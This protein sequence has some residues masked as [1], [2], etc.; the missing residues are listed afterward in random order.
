[1]Q[2]VTTRPNALD[3]FLDP[4]FLSLDEL[5]DALEF[6]VAPSG[7]LFGKHGIELRRCPPERRKLAI[8]I[9]GGGASGAYNAGLLEELLRGLR[10]RGIKV[11][12]LVGTSSGA[13]NGYGV[14]LEALGLGNPQLKT[15]PSIRQPFDSYIASAWS[16]LDRD[17][18]ASRWVVGRRSWIVQFA[19]RGLPSGW[20]KVG[21]ALLLVAMAALLQ[22]NLLLPLGAMA[23]RAGTES[24]DWIV[25]KSL[26]QS[27]PALFGCAL[28][29]T[30]LL[31][32]LGWLIARAF[33]QSLFLDLPLLR[34]L[35]NTGPDGDLGR[36]PRLSRGQAVDRARN[37]SRD[38]AD[39]WYR[40]R[41]ELPEFVITVTD[42]TAGRECLFTLVR[43]ET[44]R[45]L[46]R[47]EWMAIQFDSEPEIS[48]EYG[49]GSRAMFALPENLLRSVVASS[50][51]PG[52]FPTQRIGIYPAGREQVA[53]HHFVD[54]GVLNNSPVHVAIDAGA[55][56][57]ISLEILPLYCRDPLSGEER[58]AG[59]YRLLDAALATFTTVLERATHED[60]RR[61]ASWNRFLMAHP[62]ALGPGRGSAGRAE[63]QR[64]VVPVYRIAPRDPLVGT[65]E[66]DGRFEEG[67]RTVT[68]RDL[69]RQGILDMRGRNAWTATVRPQPG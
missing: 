1:M 49:S 11:G 64:R 27:V 55:T 52:A 21:L 47:R 38:I 45:L 68:L 61:T 7:G 42:I 10:R 32:V 51:V 3:R 48:A 54:G 18:K 41:L 33:R 22:P 66:F 5:L 16:Y 25:T 56:H 57:V 15:D 30:G 29:A 6:E 28:A 17:G 44:Y 23:A 13:V 12:L 24:L 2:Q 34:F 40:R 58:P 46:R 4:G 8:A 59:D 39:A 53:R 26:A 69:L 20:R 37:L 9:S 67:R 31:C 36:C 14:F 62:E 43:P 35:A 60:I 19:S 50:A 63:P 65:V